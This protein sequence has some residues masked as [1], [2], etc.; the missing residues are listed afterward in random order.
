MKEA[1]GA[2]VLSV[3]AVPHLHIYTYE[4][5][6]TQTHITYSF[7]ICTSFKSLVIVCECACVLLCHPCV[8]VNASACVS[9]IL[10]ACVYIFHHYSHSHLLEA[11]R[12][13]TD[14]VG[15]LHGGNAREV[16]GLLSGK[17]LEPGEE[18][19]GRRE[20]K[21]REKNEPRHKRSADETCSLPSRNAS[22]STA[23]RTARE[24]RLNSSESPYMFEIL[25]F[26]SIGFT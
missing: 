1:G 16:V 11:A 9:C 15:V 22:P 4:H 19:R 2:V 18:E 26:W 3:E 14:R 13:H 21:E 10:Q 12:S 24:Q 23:C 8:Y 7:Y 6:H 20:R 17:K 25:V 5:T